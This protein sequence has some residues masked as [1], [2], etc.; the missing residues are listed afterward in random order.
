MKAKFTATSDVAKVEVN[1]EIFQHM[2]F[3]FHLCIKQR[4][5]N[6]FGKY[7]NKILWCQPDRNLTPHMRQQF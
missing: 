7:N 3:N 1:L 4:F 6:H 2:K 5:E